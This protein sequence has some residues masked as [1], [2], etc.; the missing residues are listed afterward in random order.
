MI[1]RSDTPP[2]PCLLPLVD[3][4]IGIFGTSRDWGTSHLASLGAPT[5]NICI[6]LRH[7]V[8]LSS[9]VSKIE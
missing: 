4:A 3:A 5:P 1:I 9:K 2:H 8:A 7:F 6:H